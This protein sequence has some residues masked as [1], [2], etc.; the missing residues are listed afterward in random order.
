MTASMTQNGAK[1]LQWTSTGKKIYP[2][3]TVDK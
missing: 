2:K 3:P 1:I